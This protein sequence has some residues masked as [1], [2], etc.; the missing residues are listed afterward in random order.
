MKYQLFRSS[1]RGKAHHGWLTSRFSFSFADYHNP[2]RMGFGKLRVLNDDIIAPGTGFDTHSHNNM[3]IISIPL[4]GSLA[5]RDS[6]GHIQTIG[7]GEIQVMSAGSGIYH[8]EYNAS[9]LDD[10]NFLQIWI[11][12]E[13]RNV[14]PRYDQRLFEPELFENRFYTVVSGRKDAGH[15]WIHQDASF[16]LA[17]VIEQKKI[18]LPVVHDGYG[19]HLFV[20]EGQVVI[21]DEKLEKRDAI[22]IIG[23]FE[24]TVHASEMA[25][26]LAITVPMK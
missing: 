22:E 2:D 13:S 26:L 17:S 7:P 25:K 21:G 14:K 23:P 5:H 4:A 11:L 18:Q 12:P 15:L 10:A 9:M 16:A 3:E 8:S 1:S 20:I 24:G 6:E 19:L